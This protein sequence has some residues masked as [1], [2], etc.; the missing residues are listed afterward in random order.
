MWLSALV[1]SLFWSKLI[2]EQSLVLVIQKTE[3]KLHQQVAPLL[4]IN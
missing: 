1:Y 4:P 3:K 2:E